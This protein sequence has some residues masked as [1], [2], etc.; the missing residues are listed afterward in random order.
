[1]GYTHYWGQSKA[2]TDEQFGKVKELVGKAV[3]L[4][5]VEICD[6]QGEGEEPFINKVGIYLNGKGEFAHETFSIVRFRKGEEFCKTDRKPYDEV[7]VASLILLYEE[8]PSI[9]S[10]SSDGW[11]SD[12]DGELDPGIALARKVRKAL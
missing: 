2:L 12:P 10:W 8:F 9:F 1:M 3:E 4:S 7:V 6:G 5:D 11:L